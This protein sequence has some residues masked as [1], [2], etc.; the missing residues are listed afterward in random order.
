MIFYVDI[1]HPRALADPSRQ[2]DFDRVRRQRTQI[3]GEAANLPSESILYTELTPQIIRAKK[4]RA[5][6]I[7]GNTTDWAAYDFATFKPLFNII[8]TGLM[9][10][11]GFCGGHQLIGLMYGAKCDAIRRLN[12]GEVDPGGFVPG[13][14]KEVGFLP[15][16]VV[17]PDPIFA[18]LGDSPVFFESHY[19]EI[20]EVPQEFDLLASTANVRVQTIK[21]KQ[22]PIY[23]TQ[24][25]P[26]ASSAEHPD[27]FRLLKNFFSMV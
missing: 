24:F 2:A 25:H 17:K 1:E 14:F 5:L 19:W 16:Q 22:H 9:P 4:V 13:W 11:V 21:H 7:S 27:G 12:P 20:K 15:V 10:T 3:C 18:G 6:A 8:R 23:G 26:E